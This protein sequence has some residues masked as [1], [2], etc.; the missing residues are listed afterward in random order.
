MIETALNTYLKNLQ[1][2]S[3][4]GTAEKKASI[5]IGKKKVSVT[6]LPKTTDAGNPDFI[7]W[8]G[9]KHITRYIEAKAPHIH[10]LDPIR[11]CLIATALTKTIEL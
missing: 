1:S 5:N 3:T 6:I 9:K 10:Q 2:K 8:D 7:V 4:E 11:Y